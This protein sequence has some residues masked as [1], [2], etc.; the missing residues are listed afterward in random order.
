MFHYLFDTDNNCQTLVQLFD[1]IYAALI[2][3]GVLVFDIAEPGQVTAENRAKSFT[4]GED[5]IV[6]VDKEE[7]RDQSKL[8]RHIITLRK[9]EEYYRRDDEVH[10]LR[11]Y[12]AIDVAEKL[13]QVGFQVQMMRRYGHYELPKAHVSFIARKPM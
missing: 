13:G 6:L 3:G 12:K 8:I 11:L 2:P 4:E 9:V 10:Y 5:W 1:R 7:D